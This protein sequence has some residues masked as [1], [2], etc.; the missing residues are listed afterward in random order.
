MCT[1]FSV[2]HLSHTAKRLY[3]NVTALLLPLFEITLRLAKNSGTEGGEYL[4]L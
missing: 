4:N 2:I 3:K 1:T